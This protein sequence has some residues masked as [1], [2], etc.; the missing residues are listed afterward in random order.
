M[1]PVRLEPTASR[2]GVKPLRSHITCYKL[3]KNGPDLLIYTVFA[4]TFTFAGKNERGSVKMISNSDM[5]L[6][7][8]L[9]AL[10]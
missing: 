7:E 2:S 10:S 5:N 6:H 9:F 3:K 8:D 4:V 1:T